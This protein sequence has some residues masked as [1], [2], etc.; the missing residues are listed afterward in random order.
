[1][2]ERDDAPSLPRS[3]STSTDVKDPEAKVLAHLDSLHSHAHPV[4]NASIRSSLLRKST[5]HTQ[6]IEDL[7]ELGSAPSGDGIPAS[8]CREALAG[9]NLRAADSATARD[10]REG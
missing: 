4:S 2:C 9:A 3:L 8:L 7:L 6:N 5:L 10:V 1:M